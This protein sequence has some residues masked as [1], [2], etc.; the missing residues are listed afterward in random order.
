MVEK[1][2]K[3]R[4]ACRNNGWES[5]RWENAQE[6]TDQQDF[7][8]CDNFRREVLLLRCKASTKS[9]VIFWKITKEGVVVAATMRKPI[10]EN[11][12]HRGSGK[13][14][15]LWEMVWLRKQE[16]L[17]VV[18]VKSLDTAGS[19]WQLSCGQP[20]WEWKAQNFSG[21]VNFKQCQVFSIREKKEQWRKHWRQNQSGK[22]TK[23]KSLVA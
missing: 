2:R 14:S 20:Q 23:L 7:R 12:T 21:Q 8:T 3:C 17:D 10:K 22:R 4:A 5:R 15:C 11:N 19:N 9:K 1:A 13:K 16:G 18:Q 6:S